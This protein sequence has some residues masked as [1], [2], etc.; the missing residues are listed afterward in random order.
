MRRIVRTLGAPV[1]EPGGKAAAHAESASCRAASSESTLS[2]RRP[3]SA[4]S[5]CVA[6]LGAMRSHCCRHASTSC[7]ISFWGPAETGA[8]IAGAGSAAGGIVAGSGSVA[9]GIVVGMVGT[10][11]ALA[12]L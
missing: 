9:G 5:S 1:I 10:P 8:A 11:P 2:S 7:S 4:R 6:S 12:K 3:S